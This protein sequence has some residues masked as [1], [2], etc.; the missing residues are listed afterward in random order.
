[1]PEAIKVCVEQAHVALA[2]ALQAAS[3]NP[4]NVMGLSD[5]GVL[6]TGYMADIVGLTKDLSVG[7]VWVSGQRAR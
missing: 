1:M 4:A 3:S 5:R 6:Q 2:Q 7:A